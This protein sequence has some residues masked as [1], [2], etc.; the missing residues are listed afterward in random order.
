MAQ[1]EALSHQLAFL[2]KRQISDPLFTMA[3]D[4]NETQLCL[5][6]IALSE[7]VPYLVTLGVKQ[8]LSLV[9]LVWLPVAMC[10]ETLSSTFHPNA[11]LLLKMNILFVIISC[12]GT[13]LCESIDLARFVV[14][15]AV[16]IN[17]NWDYTDCLIPSISPILSVCAKMLKIYSHVASTLFISAWVAER[18][19]ASVFIKTYEKNNLTIGIGSSSIALITCTV[20]NGFRLVFMDYCQRM[21]YT[22]LTDKNHIAE[23][24]MFSL[25]ALEV[26]NVVILAVLFFLNRKWR[27][28]GSR[29]ETSLSHKYQIEENINAISF[30]FPLAT[31]HC[32]F[33]MATNFL[34]AF[35]AFSQSTVVSRT[36]AAARTEFIPFYYVVFPLLL[37]LRTVA[38]RNR[39]SR[40]VS[41]HYIGNYSTQVQKEENEHF[42]MLRKMFN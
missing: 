28:R 32:V 22:G 33:Y 3:I 25:A 41:I 8:L 18:V 34:M 1:R 2:Q 9:G 4:M 29:F 21:F 7:D 10:S 27:S 20:I 31:V 23:P 19:Y 14:I 37:H 30:V 13:L 39:I 42:D 40:L 15:K 36:I 12:C 11:R 38:K 5:F 17:S 24:V 26:A 6:S 35:L 16:R